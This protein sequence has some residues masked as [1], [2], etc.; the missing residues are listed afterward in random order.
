MLA[1]PPRPPWNGGRRRSEQLL[2]AFL[3]SGCRLSTVR[4]WDRRPRSAV[5]AAGLRH[6]WRYGPHRPV[7]AM[8]LRVAGGTRLQFA[9][10]LSEHPDCRTVVIEGTGFGVLGALPFLKD[11]GVRVVLVPVN[12][13]S[14][15]DYP[16]AWTHGMPLSARFAEELRWLRHA[17][18]MFTIS[19]EE[20]WLLSLH[21]VPA[22]RL[23]YFPAPAFRTE[24]LGRAAR[25]D[26]DRSVGYVYFGDFRNAPNVRG[27]S[28]LLADLRC[29]RVGLDAP[30][31]VVGRG[32]D[33]ARERFGSNCPAGVEFL[34]EVTDDRL[35]D[36]LSRCLAVVLRHPAT[37]GML[38][39]VIEL[40]LSGVP[41]LANLMALKGYADHF[42]HWSLTGP[43]GGP[44]AVRTP[45]PEPVDETAAFLA[46]V[47]DAE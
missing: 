35:E 32:L 15:V 16:R 45:V 8:S 27:F 7:G 34:G 33:E 20:A 12:V 31:T 26:P 23:P 22:V 21:G 36:L 38:T 5:A 14:L 25:R 47:W 44:P 9:Q 13:E 24:L 28:D 19:T 40:N 46:A 10:L 39:R 18:A 30:L 6:W 1:G 43:R 42:D 37:G 3:G 4:E 17:D 2:S 29:G 11:R 41:V